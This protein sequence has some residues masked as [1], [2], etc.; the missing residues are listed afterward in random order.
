MNPFDLLPSEKL[1]EIC[2]I[3]SDEDLS[4]FARSSKSISYICQIEINKRKREIEDKISKEIS[5]KE[6]TDL[7]LVYYDLQVP[8]GSIH[9]I[10][11]KW[12][13]NGIYNVTQFDNGGDFNE[14]IVT[15]WI[16]NNL[17][18]PDKKLTYYQVGAHSVRRATI[19]GETELRRLLENVIRSG[20]TFSNIRKHIQQGYPPQI[21][22]W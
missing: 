7:G 9:R 19:I 17:K 16:L 15:P 18:P 22:G 14:L 13:D 6:L 5:R 8:D 12:I 10:E 11:L 1:Y 2:E 20:Y 21:K 3:L 4:K